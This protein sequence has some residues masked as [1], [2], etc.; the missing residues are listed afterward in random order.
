[1]QEWGWSCGVG[2]VMQGWGGVDHSGMGWGGSFGL[3]LNEFFSISHSTFY[4]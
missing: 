1:M 3:G 2:W 4:K